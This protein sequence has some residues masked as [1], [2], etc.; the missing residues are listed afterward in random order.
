MLISVESVEEKNKKING[1]TSTKHDEVTVTT[2]VDYALSLVV[3]K[4]LETTHEIPSKLYNTHKKM[5]YGK[6]FVKSLQC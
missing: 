2:T 6:Y 4:S 5:F 1:A 3:N